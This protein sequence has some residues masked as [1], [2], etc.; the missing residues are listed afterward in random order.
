[1]LAIPYA[2][3]VGRHRFGAALAVCALALLS[4]CN[5]DPYPEDLKYPLRTDPL[6]V[7]EPGKRD[8]PHTYPLGTLEEHFRQ[9]KADKEANVL[10]PADLS[11][12]QKSELADQLEQV[13]GTP[14]Q[15]TIASKSSEDKDALKDLGLNAEGTLARGSVLFRRH[16]VHCH[17]LTGDG[18]GPTATWVNP[19]PR[20]Y[21]RGYFKF[22]SV[23]NVD[24]SRPLRSDLL[25][26]LR[27]GIE[28]TSMPPF[29]LLADEELHDLIS[30]VIHLSVRGSVEFAV[31]QA[32]L[33]QG[34]GSK[35]LNVGRA[36][37][38]ELGVVL[39]QWTNDKISVPIKGEKMIHP[40]PYDATKPPPP[41]SIRN[42]H[43]LFIDAKGGAC[44]SCHTDYGRQAGYMYD[45]WG[46]L[47][48]PANLTAGVYR[49]GRRPIDIYY[50]IRGGIGGTQMPETTNT[51][52]DS[53]KK[54][55]DLVNF[56]KALPYP[57]MLPD[58]V[59]EKVYGKGGDR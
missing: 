52:A 43:Q 36:V 51:I 59:R 4:G 33:Q 29:R 12:D 55:W 3:K 58:D 5:P 26:T 18:R 10:D 56:V 27:E 40:Y 24:K 38:D 37:R 11:A 42:G 46:T 28:G 53:P 30:Y 35:E 20:D 34:K 25:R 23:V 13:F 1:M 45:K 48:R 9:V 21:R 47:D 6:V 39:G 49:G 17:G 32:I 8:I 50:R 15:P 2:A 19:H 7:K 54:I 44:I 22:T 16:C 57:A 31:M 14:A 41:E